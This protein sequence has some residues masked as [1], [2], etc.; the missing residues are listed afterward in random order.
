VSDNTDTTVETA[1]A[2]AGA[3]VSGVALDA[4]VEPVQAAQTPDATVTSAAPD[5]AVETL[6]PLDPRAAAID[7]AI[8]SWIDGYVRNSPVSRSTEAWNYL[9]VS[10]GDLRDIILREI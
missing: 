4:A 9:I 7:A 5:A 2:T 6:Q 10:V 1:G 8:S 3:D